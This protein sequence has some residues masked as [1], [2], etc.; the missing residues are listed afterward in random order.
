[1]GITSTLYTKVQFLATKIILKKKFLVSAKQ[2]LKGKYGT[3][4]FLVK[5]LEQNVDIMY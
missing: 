1:M 4:Y 5:Y 2:F 3:K